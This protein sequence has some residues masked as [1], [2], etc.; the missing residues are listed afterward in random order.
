MRQPLLS[1]LADA[2]RDDLLP[3]HGYNPC[4]IIQR[5][6]PSRLPLFCIPGA[7]ASAFSLL[8]L[9]LSLPASLPVHALEAPGLAD[10]RI[11]PYNS[12][13]SYARAYTQKIRQTQAHGPYHLLGH[14]FGGWIAF[15]IA[16]QLQ[17][18]GE[19]VAN[20]ML[21]DSEAP[22]PKGR[23]PKSV[24]RV[25]TLMKL[26]EIYNMTLDQPLGLVREDFKGRDADAQLQFLFAVLKG[27]GLFPENAQITLLQGIVQVMQANLNSSYTPRARFHGQ[28]HLV[29][30][31]DSD[32]RERQGMES[33]WRKHVEELGTLVVPGNHMT[34]LLR[35]NIES[36]A[37]YL[38]LRLDTAS[39]PTVFIT[40]S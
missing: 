3:K 8:E 10:A 34:M 5:G 23:P 16:L 31:M 28:V 17:E 11:A 39:N 27:A 14:S 24:D 6:S 7:G 30:A 29:S 12:V 26:I 32:R 19:S 2:I 21:I 18:H 36:L 9:A 35:P 33:G 20:L 1:Q 37:D 22:D 4:V 40:G 25:E 38:W 13:E 15:E